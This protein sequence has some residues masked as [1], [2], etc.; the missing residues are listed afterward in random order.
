MI[1]FIVVAIIGTIIALMVALPLAGVIVF[2]QAQA[3]KQA[4]KILDSGEIKDWK[5]FDQ[6]CKM[7]S[8]GTD[9]IEAAELYRR[10]QDLRERIRQADNN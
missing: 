3:K 5:K 6:I 1:T 7:I 2:T 4:R 9:D 10:L 8:T